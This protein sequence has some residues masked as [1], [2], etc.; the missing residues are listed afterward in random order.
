M[1]TTIPT[2][3]IL[4]IDDDPD[5]RDIY[6]EVL[7]GEGYQVDFVDD[8]EKGLKMIHEGGYDL[9]LMDIMMSKIDGISILRHLKQS[10]QKS[11]V[12]NGP[13]WVIS[14][15]NHDEVVKG[16]LSLGAQG[17]I[18][19]SDLNPGEILNKIREIFQNTQ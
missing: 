14:Q 11:K 3:K 6:G 12:P 17:Y 2:K 18:V 8:G 5:I 4:L 19:K 9:I 16:A 15:L 7:K 13:L 10:P 1:N